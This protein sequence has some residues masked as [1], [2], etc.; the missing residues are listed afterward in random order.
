MYHSTQ[1]DGAL[2]YRVNYEEIEPGSVISLILELIRPGS[3]VL[4]LGCAAGSM[5][6]VLHDRHGC[7]V[8]AVEID[9]VVAQ[10]ARPFCE[11][12]LVADLETLAWDSSFFAGQDYDYILL[13]D[14]LEHLRAPAHVLCGLRAILREGGSLIVSTPNIAYAGVQAALR[15][16]WF[17]YQA[18]GLLDQGHLHFFTRAELEVM[19]LN[20]GLVPIERREVRLGP[21]DSEFSRYWRMLTESDQQQLLAAQ[22]ATVYQWVLATQLPSDTAWRRFMLPLSRQA[23]LEHQVHRLSQ[24]L[25]ALQR[26]REYT[27]QSLQAQLQA[28]QASEQGLQAQLQAIKDSHSWRLTAPLRKGRVVLSALQSR[29]RNLL[30][31]L[32][33]RGAGGALGVVARRFIRRVQRMPQ[34]FDANLSELL[35]A[36]WSAYRAWLAEYETLPSDGAGRVAAAIREESTWP[37]FGIIVPIFNPR[38]DW[39]RA[40]IASVRQQWY[41]YWRLYLVD[42]CSTRSRDELRNALEQACA[43]DSRIQVYWREHNGHISVATNDGL[44][45]SGEEWVTF[46]DQDDLLAP[47]A[48]WCFVSALRDH[49]QARVLYSDEDKID[50]HG[51]R[52]EPHFKPDW[53]PELLL[54]YNYI[55]HLVAYRRE[56]ILALGGLRAGF[57]G[58]QD[59]DLALRVTERCKPEQIVHIPRV[60]YHWR[61]HRDSTS[62]NVQAKSYSVEAGRRALLEAM[63]RRRIEASVTVQSHGQYRVSYPIHG[64]PPHVTVVVPTRNGGCLL[65]TCIDSVLAKTEYGPYDIVI[66]D[67]GSDESVTLRLLQGYAKHPQ[68]RVV[69]DPRPFNYAALHNAVVPGVRGDYVLLLNDDTEVK[70]NGWLREMVSLVMQPGV[71]AVGARLLYPDGTL[72]HGGVILVGGVAGHAHKHLAADHPG[73]MRRAQVRQNVSAV[74][75]ACMLIPKNVYLQ[76]GGMD[77]ELA[78]AFNDV[79][80]CLAIGQA[81]YR[82]VWTPYAELYHHESASRGYEDNSQKMARFQREI[83][84]MQQRWGHRLKFDPALNPNLNDMR[85]DFALARPPRLPALF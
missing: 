70:A 60:L 64:E 21:S 23:S 15:L 2:K 83:Q 52:C 4:E 8:D 5:T 82:I 57:E 85:E 53:N 13:A 10:E 79:A 62:K 33:T 26:L 71:G 80:L 14:V 48:L 18:T 72:Q 46:L 43:Q 35:T 34:G 31:T 76:V 3:R 7:T 1:Q 77:E 84:Y 65:Q 9:A 42:D 66:I 22:D 19:F 17:P 55:C 56:D 69:C 16:G 50:R 12:L 51:Q 36:D 11:R 20:C 58:A 6:R 37:R 39:L 24:E 75:A 41:P 81:G 30:H 40:A 73:Y 44:T 38:L 63:Q 32:R 47:H 78:V 25:G 49:P 54:S 61:A 27:E 45:Q 28:I 68:C 29:G 59:Y 67:N 74:T